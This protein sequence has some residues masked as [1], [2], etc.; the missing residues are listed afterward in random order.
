[1]SSSAFD[2]NNVLSLA[3]RVFFVTGGK[4]IAIGIQDKAQLTL[5]QALQGLEQD[6]FH[7]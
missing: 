5:F 3:G 2:P 6:R 1:M 4:H 7:C